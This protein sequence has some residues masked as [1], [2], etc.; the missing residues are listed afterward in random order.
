VPTDADPSALAV[1]PDDRRLLVVHGSGASLVELALPGLS[2]ERRAALARSPRAV[3]AASD[4][5]HALVSH[6]TGSLVSRVD[7]ASGS[8]EPI[9]A[10]FPRAD[11][12]G[13]GTFPLLHGFAVVEV[14]D[15]AVVPGVLVATGDTTVPTK[16]GYG[17]LATD[18]LPAEIFRVAR[19]GG[20]SQLADGDR[21]SRAGLLP[22]SC[23][24]PRSA[25]M[26]RREPWLYLVCAGPGRLYK[27]DV[28]DAGAAPREHAWS[29]PESAPDGA[30]GIALD[31]DRRIA[32]VWSDAAG[33]LALYG[34]DARSEPQDGRPAPGG[35]V[36][37]PR[38]FTFAIRPA[39]TLSAVAQRGRALFWGTNDPA[40]S[41][42]G[43]TCASC[44]IE[45]G[46]DGLTWPTPEGPRQTP[47]LAGRLANTA[48]Y[49]W[50]GRRPSIRI[51]LDETIR[52]LGGEGL[53]EPDREALVAY[54]ATLEAPPPRSP[55]ADAVA[56][57]R[58]VFTSDQAQCSRCH[59]PPSFTDGVAHDVSS[60][61]KGD[62]WREFDTP[63]LVSLS[64]T[65]PYFHDGRYATLRELLLK[66]DG[67]MGHTK[68]FGEDDLAAL[69]AYLESL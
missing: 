11:L 13:K 38:G 62:A 37:E 55:G 66:S 40:V 49:G 20:S 26:D 17:H 45:G 1:T 58:T 30:N 5:A 48:P 7:L 29:V 64:Q 65:A 19:F 9:A 33:T 68:Q 34:M 8:V 39:T 35:P 22:E 57:G 15:A 51:H 44:H 53:L 28:S 4:G 41:S 14:G 47:A 21:L 16:D 6:A 59:L 31:V 61:T 12:P 23:L 69:E 54:L 52:R 25:A 18:H 42:D 2:V 24:L 43:R 3:V 27:V 63:S 67:L 36:H 10:T 46:E 50:S 60:R 56:R 32:V